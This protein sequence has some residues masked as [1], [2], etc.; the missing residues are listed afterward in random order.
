MDELLVAVSPGEVESLEGDEVKI[1]NWLW[2]MRKCQD[3]SSLGWNLVTEIDAPDDA[4]SECSSS[5]GIELACCAHSVCHPM[6]SSSPYILQDYLWPNPPTVVER[7]LHSQQPAMQKKNHLHK[8]WELSHT[9]TVCILN[10]ITLVRIEKSP[11]LQLGKPEQKF[12]NVSLSQKKNPNRIE[13]TWWYAWTD[14]RS[15]NISEIR[16]RREH[17]CWKNKREK[18]LGAV[19]TNSNKSHDFISSQKWVDANGRH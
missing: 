9:W 17:K 13:M 7:I 10:R 16:Q 2:S 5:F 3:S 4:W 11:Y 8:Y 6:K 18:N 1:P 12:K 14:I 15:N 19:W